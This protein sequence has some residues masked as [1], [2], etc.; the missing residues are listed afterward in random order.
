MLEALKLDLLFNVILGAL[1]SFLTLIV[2][3]VIFRV[4]MSARQETPDVA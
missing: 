3:V 4:Y 1:I 2:D